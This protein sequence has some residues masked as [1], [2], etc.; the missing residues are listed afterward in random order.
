[1]T[2][3]E[4]D[5]GES[6]NL[7]KALHQERPEVPFHIFG[8]LKSTPP[9]N[10]GYDNAISTGLPRL[11][12][13]LAL[14]SGLRPSPLGPGR[15]NGRT[16]SQPA[17]STRG[18]RRGEVTEVMGPRG[19][20]KTAFAMGIAASVLQAGQ[21]VVWID[22]AGPVNPTRLN[23]ILEREKN[24]LLPDS[25]SPSHP[26]PSRENETGKLLNQLLH[27]H[28]PTLAHLLAL[29]SHP[30]KVFPPNDTGLIVVDSISSLFTSEYRT[31]LPPKNRRPK[32][33]AINTETNE[34][35]TRWKIIGNL[36]MNLKKLAAKFNCVVIAINEMASRFREGQPPVL[37]ESLSGV[38]WDSGIATRIVLCWHWL[39]PRFRSRVR[40]K[41]VRLAEVVR[42]EKIGLLHGR[43]QRVVPFVIKKGGLY[44]F[45]PR[46]GA[47]PLPLS[48][49]TPVAH[50]RS[51]RKLDPAIG[52]PDARQRLRIDS[53][54]APDFKIEGSDQSEGTGRSTPFESS[55]AMSVK[56]E[57]EGDE[58][59]WLDEDGRELSVESV[60]EDENEANNEDENNNCGGDATP[61]SHH[62]ARGNIDEDA[63]LLLQ[64]ISDNDE[65]D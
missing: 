11:D 21:K 42:T 3:Q 55:L 16:A 53:A 6:S 18:V 22:T 64:N 30:P 28:P 56:E 46:H 4:A 36:V 17:A 14:R 48:I 34:E 62:A 45:A 58:Y 13:A 50:V 60:D 10:G 59:D 39:P 63:V 8:D 20:G 43:S 35:R 47:T 37:H 49:R 1:M 54:A 26:A 41:R 32:F 5:S 25:S 40:M 27:F 33:T 44:E 57:E 51:K 24:T 65:F 15:G 52:S 29:I 9:L 31:R 12:A 7:D 38:T 23:D 19:T 2:S 61:P